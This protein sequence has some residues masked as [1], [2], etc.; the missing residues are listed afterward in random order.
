MMIVFLIA[1]SGLIY[2][3]QK[4]VA[5]ILDTH[6]AEMVAR[7]VEHLTVATHLETAAL[8]IEA[9][10]SAPPSTVRR[11]AVSEA[12]GR[13]LYGDPAFA[14]RVEQVCSFRACGDFRT[15]LG[16]AVLIGRRVPL[17]DGG[18]YAVGYD[19]QPM[20]TQLRVLPSIA[21]ASLICIVLLSLTLCVHFSLINLRRVD[22]ISRTLKRFAVG[23]AAARVPV[24][25]SDEFA[26]LGGE[27]NLALDRVNRL[28]EE[29]KDSSGRI[30]HELRTPL[31]RLQNRLISAAD[32]AKGCLRKELLFSVEDIGKVQ[33][34]FRAV[35]RIGEIETGCCAHHFAAIDAAELL[36]DLAEYYLPLAE[37][38]DCDLEI[39]VAPECPLFGDRDLLFQAIANLLDNAFKYA[40]PG[41]PICLSA[42]VVD[43]WTEISVIDRGPGIPVEA[44]ELAVQRFRRL[45]NAAN[46][47]GS[48]LGLPLAVA[49]A[50]LHRGALV[51]GDASPGLM[52]TFRIAREA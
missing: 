33:Q 23:D 21:D 14:H 16:D 1:V 24:R 4:V 44:R 9:L 30:A 37:R 22:R 19:V 17:A 46:L 11:V 42:G 27:I 35:M 36:G 52:A 6:V 18:A 31:T 12:G 43:E 49:I 45:D 51:L 34:L 47:P 32:Q 13:V 5:E 39:V 28:A 3:T 29:V 8:I 26:R 40:P 15:T 48:G 10:R 41:A 7:D 2:R 25:G 50:E 38:R 20:L